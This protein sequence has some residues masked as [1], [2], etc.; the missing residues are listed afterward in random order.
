MAEKK[1]D[2]NQPTPKPKSSLKAKLAKLLL[3]VALFA[4]TATMVAYSLRIQVW[5][6]AWNQDQWKGYLT[7]S[8]EKAKAAGDEIAAIDWS[9][10]TDKTKQ[11]W[12]KA[13]DVAKDIEEKLSGSKKTEAAT[14]P[15]DGTPAPGEIGPEHKLA[16][17]TMREGITLYRKAPSDPVQF[18]PAKKKFEEAASH[19]EKALKETNDD[20][21]KTDVKKELEDCNK[22][23][24]DCRAREKT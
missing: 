22:Y 6:W 12:N 7:F 1:R 18:A 9:K 5:P 3:V 21:Q 16:L 13:P 8:Q 14:K 10:F 11:L 24:E 23:L 19:F 2:P 20:R 15:A 4:V 17:E